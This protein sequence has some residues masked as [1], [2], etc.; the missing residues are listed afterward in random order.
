VDVGHHHLQALHR[1]RP[2][3]AE[4][5]SEGDRASRPGGRQLDETDLIAD[6]VVMAALNPAF[7]V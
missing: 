4:P 5:R 7:S 1:A 6:P 2:H 3:A